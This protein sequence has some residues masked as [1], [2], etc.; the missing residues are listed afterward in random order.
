[1][2]KKHK[3]NKVDNYN[4]DLTTEEYRNQFNNNKFTLDGLYRNLE[5]TKKG[6]DTGYSLDE[7]IKYIESIEKQQEFLAK[8]L[9]KSIY[10]RFRK[11]SLLKEQIREQKVLQ[12][13]SIEKEPV[14]TTKDDEMK[15]PAVI[16]PKKKIEH[17]I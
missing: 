3:Y 13:K 5:N 17:S 15:A 10:K 9:K 1:M 11:K 4:N 2:S 14:K 7:L 6:L 8:K 16:M 12:S